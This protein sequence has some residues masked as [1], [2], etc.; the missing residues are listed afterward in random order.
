MKRRN[1]NREVFCQIPDTRVV[2][3]KHRPAD[4]YHAKYGISL[5]PVGINIEGAVTI[6]KEELVERGYEIEP[7]MIVDN[8]CDTQDADD[9]KKRILLCFMDF[10]PA[11][12]FLTLHEQ[13]EY[14]CVVLWL[15][16]RLSPHVQDCQD[17]LSGADQILQG[18]I[19]A[20][21]DLHLQMAGKEKMP[22]LSR[23]GTVTLLFPARVPLLEKVIECLP[24]TGR[25]H[26]IVGEDDA[27]G[28]HAGIEELE[29]LLRA[30]VTVHIEVHHGKGL[31]LCGRFREDA[32][33]EGDVRFVFQV[34]PDLIVGSGK[35]AFVERPDH[36]D[37]VDLRQAFKRIEKV[38][39]LLPLDRADDLG[40]S[41]LVDPDLGN[42]ARH[43]LCPFY[44]HVDVVSLDVL[45]QELGL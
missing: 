11:C 26:V 23:Q 40:R 33:V 21:E 42:I 35:L 28:T 20:G 5:E 14:D 2:V 45:D 8:N 22:R 18:T 41:A 25:Y 31:I 9:I 12:N 34:I 15:Y 27:P 44:R 30:L 10:S 3:F 36:I 7:C 29:T 13:P 6:G 17:S 1:R 39:V 38:E 37:L 43:F 19:E 24:D 32:L 4:K 16:I